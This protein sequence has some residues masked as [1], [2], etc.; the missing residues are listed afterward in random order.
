M[1]RSEALRICRGAWKDLRSAMQ[2]GHAQEQWHERYQAG[3]LQGV[4]AYVQGSMERFALLLDLAERFAPAPTGRPRRVLDAGA[5][6]GVQA[7]AFAR[8][9]WQVSASD[10][11]A[12][13]PMLEQ[14]GIEYRRWHLEAEPAPFEPASFEAVVLSQTIEHFTHSPREPLRKMLELLVPQGILVLDA[15]NISSLRNVWRLIRGKSIMWSLHD[16][17]L[18]AE[19]EVVHGVPYYDRHNREYS[20]QDFLDI[21]RFFGLEACS[22]RYYSPIHPGKPLAARVAARIRDIVPVWRKGVCAVLRKPAA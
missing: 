7:A 16:H 18:A 9:G 6:Y 3:N 11:Y 14:L 2:A 20:R 22:I 17:W 4:D 10:V 12:Q 5:G 8:A 21:A 1:R 15:P 19:P 13:A